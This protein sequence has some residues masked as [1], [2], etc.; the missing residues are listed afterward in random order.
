MAKIGGIQTSKHTYKPGSKFIECN[1][2]VPKRVQ[3]LLARLKPATSNI[4]ISLQSA[5]KVHNQII[6]II[7]DIAVNYNAD[8]EELGLHKE[9]IPCSTLSKKLLEATSDG[10]D[11][12]SYYI[13]SQINQYAG[14]I[15]DIPDKSRDIV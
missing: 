10:K 15:E 12:F 6:T 7:N 14:L 3:S 4:E 1:P 8:R 5:I 11:R 13:A 2:D 9:T